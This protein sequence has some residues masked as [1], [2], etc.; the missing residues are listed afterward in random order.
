M[1]KAVKKDTGK[2]N[3][4]A[5]P[6][7]VKSTRSPMFLDEKYTGPEPT[8]EGWEKWSETK[9]LNEK[10][11]GMNYYNYFNN[12]KDLAP[13]LYKWMER[14][15]YPKEEIRCIREL[16]DSHITIT[17]AA[18]ATMFM[19]GMP[20]ERTDI[21]DYNPGEWVRKDIAEYII[22]GRALLEKR[23]AS[24][25]ANA[26]LHQ[27]SIQ[28]RIR[29]ATYVH[30]EEI[31]TW[32]EGFI[33]DPA[34]FDPKGFNVLNHFKSREINQAHARLIREQY[35]YSKQDYDELLSSTKDKTDAYTQLVDGYSCYTK[36]QQ[37]SMQAAL[38][39]IIA[40]CDM[41]LQKAK[42]SRKTRAKK[43]PSK[44]KLV[45]KLKF[46]PSD[47]RYKLVSIKPEEAL[48]SMELWVFNTKTRKLGVYVA[49]DLAAL[50]VKGTSIINY[51]ETKSVA[52]TVRKPEEFFRDVKSLP[53][54][55]MRKLFETINGVETKLN[56]RIGEDVVL[57]KVYN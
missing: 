21:E 1:A 44:E 9:F 56:G 18:L 53:K 15:K 46:K 47:D 40:A 19:R 7:K 2:F 38:T 16:P 49:S 33:K 28:E 17:S 43:A 48:Q 55:K 30:L 50:S 25:T 31:E 6:K 52:R 57:L 3:L 29:E 23:T 51:S 8:W 54:T 41:I 24:A 13:N 26:G 35:A 39:E 27:P 22:K 42:V 5:R 34:S 36:A 20:E 32:L 11:R 12:Y 4:T 10:R 37:R 14:S 45:A